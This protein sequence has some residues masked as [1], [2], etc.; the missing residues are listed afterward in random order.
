MFYYNKCS[1][2]KCNCH[3]FKLFLSFF[4]ILFGGLKY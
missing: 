3:F 4:V 2:L 1:K